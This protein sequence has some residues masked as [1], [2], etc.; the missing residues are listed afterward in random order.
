MRRSYISPTGHLAT[1]PLWH[2][3][4]GVGASGTW[5]VGEGSPFSLCALHLKCAATSYQAC[6]I[7]P[8]TPHT[9]LHDVPHAT[10]ALHH[11]LQPPFT[12]AAP[13]VA[14]PA[15]SAVQNQA[16]VVALPASFRP[17]WT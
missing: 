3:K 11:H 5:D 13:A 16:Y 1:I 17:F 6:H 15:Q 7:A 12:P 2:S 10:A 9:P 8:R 14:P 4:R